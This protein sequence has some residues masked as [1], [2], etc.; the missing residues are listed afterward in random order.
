MRTNRLNNLLDDERHV[1]R[2][3]IRCLRSYRFRSY[4]QRSSR[5]DSWYPA[6][7]HWID[8]YRRRD[9]ISCASVRARAIQQ[10]QVFLVNIHSA[11]WRLSLMFWVECE[12]NCSFQ[13]ENN[14]NFK[15]DFLWNTCNFFVQVLLQNE[16]PLCARNEEY[17]FATVT[18]WMASVTLSW[19]GLES[20]RIEHVH[21]S[22]WQCWAWACSGIARWKRECAS[23][24]AATCHCFQI[25]ICFCDARCDL[26][27]VFSKK[28]IEKTE[29]DK[30][31]SVQSADTP[32]QTQAEPGEET[33]MLHIR[34][35]R[36][37]SFS[38]KNCSYLF[39]SLQRHV[40]NA[41]PLFSSFLTTR[42]QMAFGIGIH[43]WCLGPQ[44]TKT[45]AAFVIS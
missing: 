40:P 38:L 19:Q 45:K 17:I 28:N 9:F 12:R 16:F 30:Q 24:W 8:S 7:G 14:L 34:L 44:S 13:T 37:L 27:C 25:F 43:R 35:N 36:C 42:W 22:E 2:W 26:Y 5:S 1:T 4:C 18:R 10:N 33:Q 29:S 3:C 32:T 39:G 21:N 20:G 15:W 11:N 6:N 31:T 41:H 23:S